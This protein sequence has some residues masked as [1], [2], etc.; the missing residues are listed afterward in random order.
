MINCGYVPTSAIK[1]QCKLITLP[2]LE[3]I[4]IMQLR[5]G[6][7][8]CGTVGGGVYELIKKNVISGK[9]QGLGANME[10]A[11]I[12][13]RTKEKLN[14]LKIDSSIHITTDYS[15]ILDDASI[16]C[17]VELMG[18]TTVAKDVILEAI[19]RGKHVVTANKAFIAQFLPELQL[20]LSDNPTVKYVFFIIALY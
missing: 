15:D 13:V 9:F 18:G 6:M 5:I 20:A 19:R 16:N 1:Y 4:L 7:F 17:V 8:G 10:I 2:L 11:K 3:L 14:D 12:C